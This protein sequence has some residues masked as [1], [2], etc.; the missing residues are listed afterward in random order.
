M[1]CGAV[2]QCNVFSL[3]ILYKIDSKTD[4]NI[5]FSNMPWKIPK[6][7]Q[8][9]AVEHPSFQGGNVPP[10][11]PLSLCRRHLRCKLERS[12]LLSTQSAI[13]LVPKAPGK[14]C[15]LTGRTFKRSKYDLLVRGAPEFLGWNTP[16]NRKKWKWGLLIGQNK[17]SMTS[18]HYEKVDFHV[19][20]ATNNQPLRLGVFQAGFKG[21]TPVL[22]AKK[23]KPMR[24]AL[25]RWGK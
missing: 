24:D 14:E 15:I 7:V 18:L 11:D 5:K 25:A 2:R 19:E 6:D 13:M 16:I 3:P 1:R 4:K 9:L 21:C 23:I 20:N 8:N 22:V 10:L 17:V 12:K